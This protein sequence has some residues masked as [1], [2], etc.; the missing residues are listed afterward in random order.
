MKITVLYYLYKDSKFLKE[1]LDSLFNQT[2]N[3]FEI[4]FIEDCTSEEI[5]DCLRQYDLSDKRI[6][7]VKFMENYGRSFAYNFALNKIK[8]SYVYFAESRCIFDAN[9]VKW[10]KEN[11]D[12]KKN[13]DWISFA[14]SE[15][16]LNEKTEDIRT[17]ING[18]YPENFLS[19]VNTKL[20]IKDKLFRTKFLLSEKIEFIQ[21]KSYFSLFIF[22]VLENYKE[23]AIVNKILVLWKRENNEFYDYNLYNILESAEILKEKINNCNSSDDKKD[24]YYTWLPILIL[25]EFLSKM[26][27][28]Y[29]NEKIVSISIKNAYDLIEK[30]DS[31]FKSNKYIS[32]LNNKAI[33]EYIKEF[34]PNYN[35]VKKVFTSM[36]K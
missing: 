32:L 15:L 11:I 13:Y 31:N 14:N 26:F 23:A 19:L 35:F 30:L 18:N 9:F 27:A 33:Y 12:E 2:D 4:V 21:F 5:H 8:G 25:F 17:V 22:D 10:F 36:G 3:N 24:A 7:V 1:S 6:K 20:T 28:S 16:D 34:K 29:E